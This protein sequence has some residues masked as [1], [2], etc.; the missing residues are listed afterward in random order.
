MKSLLNGCA[1][2]ALL[3]GLASQAH[4]QV[5]VREAPVY[6]AP[7]VVNDDEDIAP[8]AETPVI[9]PKAQA[10][11]PVM[12]MAPPAPEA[13]EV[14]DEPEARPQPKVE[15][16]KAEEPKERSV[17][18]ALLQPK[19]PPAPSL[20]PEENAFFAVLGKRV[21]DAASAYETY[22][23]RAVAIDPKF[24][25]AA[26]V[27]R[28]VRTGAAYQPQQLQEGIVAYAALL[29]LRN[30]AFVDGVKSMRDPAFADALASSPQAV[31]S[32]RGA[33][34]AAADVAGTLRA[35]GAALT[36]A[37]KSISQAAYDVQA[38]AWSKTAVSDPKGVLNDA[39]QS[40]ALPR[41]A[42]L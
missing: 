38:E 26:A 23:R 41:S 42:T 36:A 35:Q 28:A 15:L 19:A 9:A 18:K 24:T 32:V 37:G 7:T 5:E 8:V 29:A 39:K 21:T 13:L 17:V 11:P 2:V 20:T 1:A 10:K 40:A 16:V 31:L 14:A 6:S 34:Q 25:D 30:D 4:A 3:V 27:Q 22:V 33:A 12:Q